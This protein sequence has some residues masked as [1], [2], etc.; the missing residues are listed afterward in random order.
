MT[1]GSLDRFFDATYYQSSYV[2]NHF[3]HFIADY[4]RSDVD[5]VLFLVL[6]LVFFVLLMGRK[7]PRI[8]AGSRRKLALFDLE[9]LTLV[10]AV[11]V[12]ALPEHIKAQSIV[13][14]RHIVFA[15]LFFFGWVGFEGMPRRVKWS[16]VAILVG[17]QLATLGNL[18]YGFHEEDR[19][20]DDFPSVFRHVDGGKR[21]LKVLYNQ[22]SRTTD[23]GAF[24]HLHSFYM[25][26]RGGITD[27]QFAEYPHNPVQFRP[28]MVPPKVPVNFTRSPAWRYYDYVLMRKS[29]MPNIRSVIDVLDPVGDVADWIVYRVSLG[30]LPRPGGLDAIP[31]P[32]RG[33]PGSNGAMPRGAADQRDT[34]PSR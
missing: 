12:L 25:I 30:P 9:V 5:D 22:E 26:E 31:S 14:L 6:M 33:E 17:V 11:S 20:L 34:V 10:L 7:A 28:G 21:L 8:P 13:S 27:T 15:L 4:F 18:W 1:F 32:R 24:W 2:V 29:S 3:F 19:E 16:A 23:Y